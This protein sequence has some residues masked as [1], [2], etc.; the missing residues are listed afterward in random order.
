MLVALFLLAQ[1]APD[2]PAVTGEAAIEQALE[3][4]G[5]A[6]TDGDLETAGHR[7]GEALG[8]IEASD[9]PVRE[10]AATA[11]FMA[12]IA[13]SAFDIDLERGL[14]FWIAA[15]VDG[16][17]GGVL[18]ENWRHLAAEQAATPGASAARDAD[19]LTSPYY[20]A[21]PAGSPCAPI[22]LNPARLAPDSET[23]VM[24]AAMDIGWTGGGRIYRHELVFGYP[25][26]E[27]EVFAERR[28]RMRTPHELRGEALT[29]HVLDP[30]TRI[31]IRNWQ[32]VELCRD[33]LGRD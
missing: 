10:D 1:P 5:E 15:E 25:L 19:F 4:V 26:H 17:L 28:A 11:A 29:L 9:C 8:L 21:E 16:L 32:T 24:I 22:R 20:R 27:A 7:A 6:W 30:C 12:A 13:Q 23:S 3:A 31:Q 14:L 33:G 2:L 18:P